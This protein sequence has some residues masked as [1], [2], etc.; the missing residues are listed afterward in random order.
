MAQSVV[1]KICRPYLLYQTASGD[2]ASS[3]GDLGSV[4]YPFTVITAR[5]TLTRSGSTS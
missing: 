3:S 1:I 5:S 2:E 4:E